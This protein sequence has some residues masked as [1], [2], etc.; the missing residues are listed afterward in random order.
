MQ[1]QMMFLITNFKTLYLG[2]K[3]L[4]LNKNHQNLYKSI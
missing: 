1:K 4:N 3:F 2:M